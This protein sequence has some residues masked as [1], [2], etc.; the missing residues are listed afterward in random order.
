[1]FPKEPHIK[2][3][4]N[5]KNSDRKKLQSTVKKQVND[6]YSLPTQVIKQTSFQI[7]NT[8]GSIYTDENNKPIW[9]KTK[10]ED[11]LYPTI[12]SLWNLQF[13]L[14]PVILTHDFVI[15]EHILG[16][17]QLMLPGTVPPFPASVK[18]GTLVGIASTKEPLL[19]KAIGIAELDLCDVSYVIGTKGV[20]VRVLHYLDDGLFKAFKLELEPVTPKYSIESSDDSV[21]QVQADNDSEQHDEKAECSDTNNEETSITELADALEEMRVEDV[22]HMIIR[23][24]KYTIKF[25]DKITLPI[26]ASTF[27][28]NH[29]M[30]NLPDVDTNAVNI[31][32]SSWKKATKLLKYLEDEG[33]LKLKGKNENCTV[34]SLNKAHA[35]LANMEA[36]KTLA[37]VAKKLQDNTSTQSNK[38]KTTA[39]TGEN[40]YKPM[41]SAQKF[42]IAI[43]AD[44]PKTF[45]TRQEIK[46]LLDLYVANNKLIDS[47]NKS[48]VK[49]D[50]TLYKMSNPS[51]QTGGTQKIARGLIPSPT[52]LSKNFNS[53]HQI[54]KANGDPLLRSPDKGPIPTIEIVTEKKIGRKVITRV[55]NFEKFRIDAEELAAA[56]R[57]KC[58][59][60]TT[61]GESKAAKTAEVQVQGPHGPTVISILNDY[62]IPTKW[63]S[64]EN[65]IKPKQK[66][67]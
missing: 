54:Y 7:G 24:V 23:A 25:D 1:M 48:L 64:F 50:D 63:T 5:L 66:K 39:Y 10:F 22:D 58:S 44:V 59:G 53:Y 35:D 37:S 51:P 42:I 38:S 52:F 21:S 17:A 47:E 6:E 33:L 2:P 11:Q 14:L 60:S 55:T 4:S 13:Q 36:Y 8:A 31:K 46:S 19:V 29:V 56:L 41:S 45:Y 30:K 62:G 32:K 67:K 26:V 9:F 65:K 57:K 40:L 20:A 15:E 12:F 18:K 27:I 49:Y 28:S 43:T 34:I 3:L 61:I 16:G